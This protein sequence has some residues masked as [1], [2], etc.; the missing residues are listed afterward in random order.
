MTKT[1]IYVGHVYLRRSRKLELGAFSL[2]FKDFRCL[3]S[4]LKLMCNNP[5][6]IP[7]AGR[8]QTRHMSEP[9]TT[10]PRSNDLSL[11]NSNANSMSNEEVQSS[12]EANETTPGDDEENKAPVSRQGTF[13]KEQEEGEGDEDATSRAR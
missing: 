6:P 2:I 3:H 10:R 13:S 4:L 1:Y 12:N 7:L 11:S 8:S 5:C 9:S